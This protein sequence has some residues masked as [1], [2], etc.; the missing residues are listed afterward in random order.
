MLYLGKSHRNIASLFSS[1]E[2]TDIL[3]VDCD[4]SFVDHVLLE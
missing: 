4:M 2:H 3:S 1:T